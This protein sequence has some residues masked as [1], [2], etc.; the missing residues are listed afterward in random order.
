MNDDDLIEMVVTRDNLREVSKLSGRS[1][2]ALL[3]HLI[4]YE[5]RGQKMRV[6][7]YKPTK[8]KS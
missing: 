3:R 8:G 4:Q 5:T 1:E 7:V 2:S 6:Q